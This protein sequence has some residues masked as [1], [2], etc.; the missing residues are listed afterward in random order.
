MDEKSSA[1]SNK[2]DP[3][4]T[5]VAHPTV[6]TQNP[7]LADMKL[8][9]PAAEPARPFPGNGK[10]R[11]ANPSSPTASSPRYFVVLM[12]GFQ[13]NPALVA[14]AHGLQHRHVFNRV[15]N[16]FSAELNHGQRMA[17]LQNPHVDYL[18]PV[19][20]AYPT[21]LAAST[22]VNRIDA[23]KN[24]IARINDSS[25]GNV[26][27]D[28]AIID[29]EVYPT[30]Q[31]LNI[32][33]ARIKDFTGGG[34]N[35][36]SND[37][38]G[39]V[40]GT[41][42][43]GIAA[44]YDDGEGSVGVAPGARIWSCKVIQWLG[45]DCAAYTDDIVAALDWITCCVNGGTGC[46]QS[47]AGVGAETAQDIRV[48]NM[49][50]GGS[51]SDSTCSGACV[52]TYP[53]G[54]RDAYHEAVCTL[55]QAG[56]VITTSAG[57]SAMDSATQVPATYD[58]VITVSAMT[59]TDGRPGRLGP[60]KT[61]YVPPDG[62][63][64]ETDLDDSFACFSNF[65][66]D[67]DLLAPG[68]DIYSTTTPLCYKGAD[69]QVPLCA[70]S[71]EEVEVG[72][73][74]SCVDL[75]GRAPC[76]ACSGSGPTTTCLCCTDAG[77]DC[78]YV[79]QENCGGVPDCVYEDD[80]KFCW[81][82]TNHYWLSGTSQAAPHVAGAAALYIAEH[83]GATPAEVKAALI[84]AGDPKPCGSTTGTCTDDTVK[85]DPDGIQ[86]PGLRVWTVSESFEE[87]SLGST[88]GANVLMSPIGEGYS[89]VSN[90]SPVHGEHVLEFGVVDPPDSQSHD[91][92]GVKFCLDAAPPYDEA[93][94]VFSA[95]FYVK[96][97]T[98]VS[99]SAIGILSSN[100]DW[101][102]WWWVDS[103][104]DVFEDRPAFAT[105]GTGW[106]RVEI[107]IDRIAD[108][109]VFVL[110]N[111]TEVTEHN[112]WPLSTTWPA[113]SWQSD[114]MKCIMLYTGVQDDMP[115]TIYVDNTFIQS[116]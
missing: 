114:P 85:P 102:Y 81:C 25:D 57:N 107:L 47:C 96:F 2:E 89:E 9:S 109:A 54:S 79:G 93:E 70:G 72:N 76:G 80:G 58:E 11:R 77:H 13:G 108:E 82:E 42:V 113:S 106:N 103:L 5:D 55:N 83:P 1:L 91:Y 65:G 20:L 88:P 18:E 64:T 40:H 39:H 101:L 48:A 51:G 92:A 86:E 41:H 110:D 8:A 67:V 45:S 112:V 46:S 84:A 30:H 71:C 74:G 66:P 95:I 98:F 68:Q 23:D 116:Q 34:A 97:D 50:L 43:A 14:Q 10:G 105:F 17:L 29:S 69:T 44:A 75:V 15:F 78:G 33:S 4:D 35:C 111:G 28:I 100:D 32:A 16:G 59:D 37:L 38:G 3:Q 115:Q 104:G 21:S 22:G 12:G 87:A 90:V 36:G 27:A 94:E 60:P 73:K 24:A 6:L 53:G 61:C 19:K 49:S 56:V 26:D 7:D 99:W 63:Q 52:C 62:L 31:D